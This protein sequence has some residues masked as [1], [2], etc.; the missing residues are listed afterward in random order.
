MKVIIHYPFVPH[1]RKAIFNECELSSSYEFVFLADWD[2][3]FDGIK[4]VPRDQYFNT[5]KTSYIS[6]VIPFF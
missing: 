6:I 2:G 3:M 4:C 5:Y 1:Y